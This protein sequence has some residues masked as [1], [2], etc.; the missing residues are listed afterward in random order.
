MYLQTNTVV[1]ENMNSSLNMRNGA[2]GLFTEDFN[3]DSEE[4]FKTVNDS[5]EV[6][7]KHHSKSDLIVLFSIPQVCKKE[8]LESINSLRS[9]HT[10]KV[11]F[12]I[13]IINNRNDRQYSYSI[14]VGKKLVAKLNLTREYKENIGMVI[15]RY[16]KT[17]PVEDKH[18]DKS[19][20]LFRASFEQDNE[21]PSFTTY[22]LQERLN[23]DACLD[24]LQRMYQEKLLKKYEFLKLN[25]KCEEN[26]VEFYRIFCE[27]AM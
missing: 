22:Q 7:Q 17:C 3:S 14:Y 20:Q 16:A 9:Q 26:F 10:H 21:A 23:Q 2:H 6:L 27:G 11:Y 8:I 12:Y 1:S 4:P 15:D 5:R 19:Q 24:Y 18:E 25:E 13:K